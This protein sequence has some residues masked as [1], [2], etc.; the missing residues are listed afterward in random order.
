MSSVTSVAVV[1]PARD[2]ELLL[3]DCLA[4][5]AVAREAL[6]Q[7]RPDIAVTLLVVLDSCLDGSDVVV[8]RHPGVET[9][10]ASVGGVG[11]ARAA[12]AAQVLLR[13]ED[14]DG[15]W[16]ASTDADT[17][18]PPRWLVDQVALA[19]TGLDLVLGT[20]EPHGI[21]G[22]LLRRWRH[23]HPLHEGHPHVHGANLGVRASRYVEVGGFAGVAVHEDVRL[24]EAV[25]ATGA[26]W[27]ATDATRVRTAG[28]LVSRVAGGFATYLRELADDHHGGGQRGVRGCQ[29]SSDA[30]SASSS[31]RVS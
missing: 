31:H 4:A 19:E 6:V 13:S 17:L 18:V 21:E 23:L 9:L 29:G 10:P 20:V 1:V 11:A 2:E 3:P 15:L 24:A 27:V 8:G 5:L 22:Q 7:D 14:L 28:R 12:G 30:A 16:L 25:K 26:P